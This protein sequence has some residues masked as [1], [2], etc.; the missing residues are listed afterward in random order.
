L[1]L[2]FC[3]DE[4]VGM[5]GNGKDDEESEGDSDNCAD[6]VD[7]DVDT[8]VDT[9]QTDTADTKPADDVE[10]ED[11]STVNDSLSAVKCRPQTDSIDWST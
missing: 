10:A 3:A 5:A 6:D 8:A 11:G 2:L 7:N 9:S 1:W 4:Y